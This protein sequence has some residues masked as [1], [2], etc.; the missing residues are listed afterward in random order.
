MGRVA[1]GADQP[2]GMTRIERLPTGSRITLPSGHVVEGEP[3]PT[4]AYRRTAR[5]LGYGDD[6]LAMCRDHDPLH[7]PLAEWL[8]LDASFALRE[9]A[10]LL[11]PADAHKAR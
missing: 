1:P 11:D 10:G 6:T 9:A 7:A 8:G 5:E 3:E 2:G 4:E